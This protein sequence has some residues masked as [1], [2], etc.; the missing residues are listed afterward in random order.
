[1]VPPFLPDLPIPVYSLLHAK[2]RK[3]QNTN[4]RSQTLEQN[5]LLER[6]I[7]MLTINPHPEVSA[8]KNCSN[9]NKTNTQR[10]RVVEKELVEK[11][12]RTRKEFANKTPHAMTMLPPR[13]LAL[14]NVA[15]NPTG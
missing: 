10:P 9:R 14:I 12:K 4:K 2:L 1:M 11:K 6:L 8:C 3:K 15:Q 7:D 13:L 5:L